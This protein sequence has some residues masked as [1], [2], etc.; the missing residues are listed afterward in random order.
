MV[1]SSL[2]ILDCEIDT[3]Q[4]TYVCFMFCLIE[5]LIGTMQDHAKISHALSNYWQFAKKSMNECFISVFIR[6]FLQA[7][8]KM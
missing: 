5:G 8:N 2:F 6:V 7:N 4:N 1:E 3:F